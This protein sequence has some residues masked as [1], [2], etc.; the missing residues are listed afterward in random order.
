MPMKAEGSP[1]AAMMSM[2]GMGQ[3]GG[4]MGKMCKWFCRLCCCAVCLFILF[5][6][7]WGIA[8]AALNPFSDYQVWANYGSVADYEQ[9]SETG[10]IMEGFVTSNLDSN[11]WLK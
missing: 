3:Q 8:T 7:V 10:G 5:L 6:I 11:V 2:Q 1:M 4:M 9:M